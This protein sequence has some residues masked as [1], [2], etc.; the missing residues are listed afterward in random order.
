MGILFSY[1]CIRDYRKADF[2]SS[3]GMAGELHVLKETKRESGRRSRTY[4]YQ[5]MFRGEQAPTNPIELRRSSAVEAGYKYPVLFDPKGLKESI[6]TTGYVGN[7]SY[8]IAKKGMSAFEIMELETGT[9][10]LWL[11]PFFII[12]S[13]FGALLFYRSYWRGES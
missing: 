1:L 3:A 12:G 2:L 6:L 5:A 4:Y 9:F 11:G 10:F 13:L 7:D 8:A